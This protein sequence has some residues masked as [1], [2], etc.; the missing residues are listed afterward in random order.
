MTPT[1]SEQWAKLLTEGHGAAEVDI[2][3]LFGDVSRLHGAGLPRWRRGL[4]RVA[5]PVLLRGDALG[6]AVNAGIA[7]LGS[8]GTAV[9]AFTALGDTVNVAARLQQFAAG[10]ELLVAAG[11]IDDIRRNRQSVRWHCGDARN[12]STHPF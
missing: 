12:R 11:A 3:V 9:V 2:A 1:T 7:Y 8:V 5:Q 4:R 6:A 10:G